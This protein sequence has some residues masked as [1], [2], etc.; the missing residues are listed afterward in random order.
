M[1]HKKPKGKLLVIGGGQ[2][3]SGE[4]DSLTD[5]NN[6]FKRLDI[7]KELI[8]KKTS[9]RRKY[10]EVITTASTEP[11]GINKKYLK[12]F[13]RL[14]F[15]KVGFIFVGSPLESSNLKFVK[16]IKK[17]HA[18]LFS[19]G[20]QFR[21]STILGNTDIL[22]AIRQRYMDDSEFIVAGS[23]AGAMAFPEIMILG[24]TINETILNTPLDISTGFGFISQ[25]IIDT[26]FM[27]RGRFGRLSHAVVA[28]PG[29]LGLGIGEKAALLV[30]GG[31]Y[32]LCIG[33]GAVVVIDGNDVIYTNVSIAEENEALCAE[34]LKVHILSNGN[35]FLLKER[36]LIPSKKDVRRLLTIKKSGKK[37][38]VTKIK[39]TTKVKK[40]KS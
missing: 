11:G 7:L 40:S 26:H 32:A 8:P 37:S 24:G 25:C 39:K 34:N 14:G 1:L 5:E 17:A 28:N 15:S 35:G 22:N 9:H 3:L 18:V 30:K 21:L 31:N 38:T 19:G 36:K 6:D 2:D 33:S 10:I 20:N 23:S 27:H 16:R 29:I 4:V 12:A 13:K